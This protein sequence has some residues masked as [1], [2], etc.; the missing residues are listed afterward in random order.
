MNKIM[1]CSFFPKTKIGS[2]HKCGKPLIE[3]NPDSHNTYGS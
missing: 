1:D 2:S 3:K